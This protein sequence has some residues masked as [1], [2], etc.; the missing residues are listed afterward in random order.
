MS[1]DEFDL[2]I[3]SLHRIE[4]GLIFITGIQTVRFIFDYFIN[5]DK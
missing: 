3:S 2:I 4:I 5:G 1:F